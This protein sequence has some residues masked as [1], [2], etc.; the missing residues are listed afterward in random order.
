MP[1]WSH[2]CY[3]GWLV[4]NIIVRRLQRFVQID[5]CFLIMLIEPMLFSLF[6]AVVFS[7]IDT[8]FESVVAFVL[9]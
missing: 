8:C 1:D 9:V 3:V 4:L 5:Y 6:G 2:Y 7:I